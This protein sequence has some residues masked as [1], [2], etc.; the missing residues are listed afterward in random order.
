MRT[1]AIQGGT[2]TFFERFS[3]QLNSKRVQQF[4]PWFERFSPNLEQTKNGAQDPP[5]REYVQKER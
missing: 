1:C 2:L 3:T 4:E 5:T